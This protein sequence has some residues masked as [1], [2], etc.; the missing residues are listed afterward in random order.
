MIKFYDRNSNVLY[1]SLGKPSSAVSS[2]LRSGVLVR[3]DR[4]TGEFV[5]VTLIDFD[6]SRKSDYESVLEDSDKVPR[7]ILPK[8]FAQIAEAFKATRAARH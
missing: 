8:L 6:V 1:I 2:P 4:K 5:G 7:E 3:S